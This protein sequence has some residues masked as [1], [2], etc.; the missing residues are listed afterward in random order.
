MGM[1]ATGLAEYEMISMVVGSNELH[2][3]GDHGMA[4]AKARALRGM[5]TR[6]PIFEDYRRHPQAPAV[7]WENADPWEGTELADPAPEHEYNADELREIDALL[8]DAGVHEAGARGV[9]ELAGERDG[10]RDRVAELEAMLDPEKVKRL[11]EVAALLAARASQAERERDDAVAHL[12][13][14]TQPPASPLSRTVG[15]LP[16]IGARA[17]AAFS[18]PESLG[19][20]PDASLGGDANVVRGGFALGR[21]LAIPEAPEE[22]RGG[23]P[24][25][26]P[27]R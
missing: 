13:Q 16:P 3:F 24:L 2:F 15:E 25:A 23:R 26:L 18:G 1:P 10:Y 17:L 8:V 19:I 27:Y 20:E 21:G 14:A 4:S 9:A 5:V 11:A 22:E 6:I 12:R 7:G